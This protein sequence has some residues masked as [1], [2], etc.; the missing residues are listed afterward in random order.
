MFRGKYKHH[1][2]EK[3]R[4]ALPNK[5]REILRVK[6]GSEVLIVTNFP[7]YLV[8]YPLEEWKKIEE[9]L[10]K[11]PWDI[12]QI[13]QYIRYFWGAAEECY[14]DRQG[15][16]L[17]PQSLREEM[18]LEKEI[19]L[20]GMLNHFEIWNPK[21]LEKE[22]KETK[23]NFGQLWKQVSSFLNGDKNTLS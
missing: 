6:Y 2:D 8:V 14:P 5:F 22:F 20:V 4:V 9:K 13:R 21:V 15:R 7:D 1:L 23:E 18:K 11:L 16:L 3:G 17:I 19:V 12:P 10:L